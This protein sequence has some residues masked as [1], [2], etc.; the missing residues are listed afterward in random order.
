MNQ[1]I[2]IEEYIKRLSEDQFD[3]KTLIQDG[4]IRRLEI[5]GE[6]VKHIPKRIRDQYPVIPW[7]RITGMRDRGIDKNMNN[8]IF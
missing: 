8:L 3:E 1:L 7:R 6:A 2:S 5:I 4:V